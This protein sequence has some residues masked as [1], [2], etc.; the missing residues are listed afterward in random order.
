MAKVVPPSS[1]NRRKFRAGSGEDAGNARALKAVAELTSE[2]LPDKIRFLL[3]KTLRGPR[4]SLQPMALG[5]FRA[6]IKSRRMDK[7]RAG[8]SL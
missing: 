4:G 7:I 3:P 2:L 5:N 8:S 1:S 6:R